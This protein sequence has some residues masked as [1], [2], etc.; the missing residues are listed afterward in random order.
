MSPLEIRFKNETIEMLR[1]TKTAKSPQ[2]YVDGLCWLLYWPEFPRDGSAKE[3]VELVEED[4]LLDSILA[5]KPEPED[6]TVYIGEEN[7]DETLRSFG[8]IV[9]HYSVAQQAIG[10]IRVI[11]PPRMG[12][13]QPIGGVNFLSSLMGQLVEDLYAGES[14]A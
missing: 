2:H 9:C 10:T 4:V 14:L 8:V 7:E 6:A 11:A 1:D 13:S 12:Y 3:L 5:E